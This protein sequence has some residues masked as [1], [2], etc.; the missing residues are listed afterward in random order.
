MIAEAVDLAP[1][2]GQE[3][4]RDEMRA[5]RDARGLSQA[6]AAEA[7]GFKGAAQWAD[8]ENGRKPNVTLATLDKIATALD[9]DVCE[10][11]TP[12]KRK[13]RRAD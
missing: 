7:A 9:C 3:L 2:M 1:A 12:R 13:G 5:R 10:L 4:N 11:I 8:I 6:A